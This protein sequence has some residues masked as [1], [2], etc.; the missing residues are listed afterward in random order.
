MENN[1]ENGQMNENQEKAGCIAIGFSFVFPLV[2]F[3][4]Y[5]IYKNK[6]SN[7]DSYLY[8]AFAGIL[9]GFINAIIRTSLM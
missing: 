9:V 2:G 6:V 3:I 8:A 5:F 4:L 1:F 7:P